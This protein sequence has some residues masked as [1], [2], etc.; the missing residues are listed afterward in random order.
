[1]RND[2]MMK[3]LFDLFLAVP[4]FLIFF[5]FGLVIAL[6]LKFTGEG[7]IFFVQERVG[8]GD[9]RF[10][11]LKFATMLRDSPKSGTITE[12]NDPRILP[13]GRYLRATKIN[14]LPQILN[15][16]K[17][18]MSIV[19][20]RPLA[21]GEFIYYPDDIKKI[22]LQMKPGLTGMGSLFLRN[23]EV[24]LFESKKE[25]TRCYIEDVIPLKGAL[26]KWY[27]E[28]RSFCV[29][30]KIIMA[31]ALAIVAPG[32][33]FYL[34]WFDV[35]GLVRESTLSVYFVSGK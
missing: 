35:E 7:W 22:I 16:I 11:L 15:V 24:I 32:A 14:E 1:M 5:P 25:K 6:I 30:L 20:P 27:F 4:A 9:S 10:G 8:L 3:R 31:T 13:F 12:K 23:E 17:S 29:D 28:H 26:E 18:D 19:G 33:R 21:E 34:G 2:L